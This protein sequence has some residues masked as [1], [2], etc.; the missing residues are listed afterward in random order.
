VKIGYRNLGTAF[1]KLL[2]F[3]ASRSYRDRF[4]LLQQRFSRRR[5]DMPS[6]AQD[7]K[8][9]PLLDHCFP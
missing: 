5:S 3:A 2:A 1:P 6:G 9:H 7:Y 4:T 8:H